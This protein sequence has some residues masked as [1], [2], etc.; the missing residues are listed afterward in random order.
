MLPPRRLGKPA[1]CRIACVIA[2]V[3]DLPL[4]PVTP[5][6]R[7]RLNCQKSDISLVKRTPASRAFVR[8]GLVGRHRRIDHDHVG[9]QKIRVDVPAQVISFDR[10]VGQLRQRLGR[11]LRPR[12]DRSP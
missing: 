9:V 6:V 1:A 12:A 11:D 8:N 2:A 10:A 7:L 3:V 5:M 4:L